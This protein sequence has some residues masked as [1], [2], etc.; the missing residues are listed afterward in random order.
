MK[1]REFLYKSTLASAA[2]V[3]LGT[4]IGL[5]RPVHAQS[6][7]DRIRIGVIG[8]G[9]M[10]SG[11]AR[12]ASHHGEI[13]AIADA[14]LNHAE[15]LKKHFGGKPLV[16]QD[17]RKLLEHKDIDV[18]IQG[19]PDHWHTKINVDSFRAGKD[20]YGE[21]PVTLTIDEGKLLCKT[22]KAE[23]RVFQ[24]GTQQRSDKKFQT[25]I[26]LVRNGRIGKLKRVLVALPYYSS[27]GGPFPSDGI[28]VPKELDWDLYQGQAPTK[29]YIPQRTHQ[30]FRWWY[31]YAGGMVTDWGNHHMDIAHWG[32]DM[33][34]SGPLSVEARAIFP[35]EGKPDCFNTPDRFY[36]TLQYPNDIELIF[37][38][39]F[40]EKPGFFGSTGH[41]ET[42][43]EQLE[44]L[45]GKNP[46][47]EV[48]GDENNKPNERNGIMFIGD[49]GRLFVNRGNVYGKP[50]EELKENPLPDNAWKTR[51]STNHMK[52]F[53]D[54][55]RSRETPVASADVEHHSIIPCHL[56]NISIKL[57]GRKINWDATKEEITNDKEANS[58]LSREQ[59][60]QYQVS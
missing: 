37:Y 49:K 39:V 15:A 44:W 9:G 46:P 28:A 57:N 47:I 11:D 14:D 40:A 16:Y 5:T 19:T 41:Q 42:S 6:A 27:W 53:F 26:E 29:P 3:T 4:Q 48:T 56:T 52:N 50:Y 18:I 36:A 32:M 20:V 13:V 21:K 54:C 60:K 12:A 55:V 2:A 30:I 45:F 43:K 1:R 24:T 34:N 51:P 10:G 22:V 7:N 17:Y 23:K 38:T 35:N 33:D 31:E 58:M 59:R 8:A 25:A